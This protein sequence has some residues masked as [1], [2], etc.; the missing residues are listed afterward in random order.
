LFP[1]SFN[2]LLDRLQPM[3]HEQLAPRQLTQNA[4]ASQQL[5]QRASLADAATTT[6][7]STKQL[8]Y[9]TTHSMHIN[10][11]R[12]HCS[13]VCCC[14][15]TS[16]WLKEAK[17]SV[18]HSLLVPNSSSIMTRQLKLQLVAE[19]LTQ[20]T[21]VVTKRPS[22][23]ATAPQQIAQCSRQQ[24]VASE[25]AHAAVQQ[26]GHI[27]AASAQQLAH[28]AA[29]SISRVNQPNKHHWS[30]VSSALSRVRLPGEDYFD[31]FYSKP[32]RQPFSTII[33][34]VSALLLLLLDRK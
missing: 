17:L 34:A 4:S 31:H 9:F 15:A 23:A 22:Q 27:A 32:Y 12:A 16:T 20:L 5:T 26:H 6:T 25:C 3:Q 2:S 28:I 13:H 33:T 8:N 1:G 14:Q 30:G 7:T 24:L 21:S 11:P 10:L 29:A 18:S 19:Q